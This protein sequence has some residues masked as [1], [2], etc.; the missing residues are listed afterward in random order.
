MVSDDR[1]NL[2]LSSSFFTEFCL[3][4]CFHVHMPVRINKTA[5]SRFF[6]VRSQ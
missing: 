6:T 2:L 4:V 1:F 5:E 3:C